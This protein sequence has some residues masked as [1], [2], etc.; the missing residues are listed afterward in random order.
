MQLGLCFSARV[1]KALVALAVVFI[2]SG[3]ELFLRYSDHTS[4]KA[5]ALVLVASGLAL[6]GSSGWTSRLLVWK[7]VA[8]LVLIG[9]MVQA[10]WRFYGLLKEPR[11]YGLADLA[12]FSIKVFLFVGLSS[13]CFALVLGG[14]RAL[15]SKFHG[16]V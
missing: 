7:A 4:S 2:I 6:L 9:Y 5:L 3:A 12:F 15:F 1:S 10:C 13:F 14:M 8:A 16:P 11:P